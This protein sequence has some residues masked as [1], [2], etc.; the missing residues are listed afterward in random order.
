MAEKIIYDI[1]VKTNKAKASIKSLD[2]EVSKTGKLILQVEDE[3]L[4]EFDLKELKLL[5]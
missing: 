3:L 4:K 2:K 5:Y 1:Q